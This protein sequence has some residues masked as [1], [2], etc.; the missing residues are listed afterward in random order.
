MLFQD[1]IKEMKQAAEEEEDDQEPLDL[2]FPKGTKERFIYLILSPLTY[3]LAYTVPDVRNPARKKYFML[4]FFLAIIWVGIYSFFMVEF[5]TLIGNHVD[6]GPAHLCYCGASGA[7]RHG[8]VLLHRL[9]H[10]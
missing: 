3:S 10:F 8:S 9:Q 7:G 4:T 5:A 6:P 2:T 1:K